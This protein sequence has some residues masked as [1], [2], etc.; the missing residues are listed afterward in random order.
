MHIEHPRPWHAERSLLENAWVV[1]DANGVYIAHNLTRDDARAIAAAPD[2]AAA[3]RE[4]VEAL[5]RAEAL[6]RP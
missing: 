6:V 1:V 3:V 5:D 2:F 4:A